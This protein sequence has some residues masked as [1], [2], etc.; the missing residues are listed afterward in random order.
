MFPKGF[1]WGASSSAFQI[2]GAWNEDGKSMTVADYNSFKKNKLQA[3]T[4]VASNFYHN[5]KDDI[6]LM[7]KLGLTMYRFSLSWARIIPSGDGQINQKGIDFYND[8]IDELIKNDIEPF[9]TLYHFDLPFNLVKKYNGWA[10]RKTVDAFV[11]YAKIC[12]KAFGDR[13]KRWQ[14]HNEQNLMIRVN[15]RMNIYNCPEEE[16]EPLRVKMDHHM[17]LAYAISSKLCKEMVTGGSVGPSISATVSYPFSNDPKDVMSAI[18]NNRLKTDYCIDTHVYGKYPNYYLNYLKETNLLF[19]IPQEEK[20][21]ME[22]A[23][24]DFITVNYYR[25]LSTKFLPET[26][27]H[28]KGKRTQGTN[29]ADYNMYGY[30]EIVKNN[31]LTVTEYGAQI[32]PTGLRIALNY[33]W[34][35]YKKPLI[36][37][38]NGL[39]TEDIFSNNTVNDDYRIDYI[40]KHLIAIQEAINDGVNIFGYNVWSFM[41]ILSSH[42]GFKKRYG[43]VYVNRTDFDLKDLKRYP[44]KSFYWYQGV[45]QT[46][47]NSLNYN[48]KE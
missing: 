12:F 27:E 41:D 11:N 14:I 39:G 38:E 30:W 3:D 19:D 43:L 9:I 32:D 28:P 46:N 2:E 25:S 44:K 24:V 6:K 29:I 10:S 48:C 21:I 5:Y 15:E 40:Q 33:Y 31:H 1:Y 35:K 17:F 47:G 22:S 45:I 42:Q 37:T 8:V 18:W 4:K 13:V 7:K 34:N 20:E 26:D 16:I 23:V 36:I